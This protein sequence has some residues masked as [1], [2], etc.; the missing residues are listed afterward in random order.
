VLVDGV[1]ATEDVLVGL[2]VI[3]PVVEEL[4]LDGVDT[5]VLVG[6]TITD[7][8]VEDTVVVV[9]T[10]VSDLRQEQTSCAEL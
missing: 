9:V 1:V 4:E 7:V 6:V 3:G 5:G 2:V 8:E 10:A